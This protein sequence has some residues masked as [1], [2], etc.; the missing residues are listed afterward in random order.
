MKE[1][2]RKEVAQLIVHMERR[3]FYYKYGSWD[4]IIDACKKPS[5]KILVN[6]VKFEDIK[7]LREY[8]LNTVHLEFV[9]TIKNKI[10]YFEALKI[11]CNTGPKAA[12][13]LAR[14]PI[15]AITLY[16][17]M[18]VDKKYNHIEKQ[19]ISKLY[20]KV[21]DNNGNLNLSDYLHAYNSTVEKE[22]VEYMLSKSKTL[23]MNAA[24][25]KKLIHKLRKYFVTK[26]NTYKKECTM[27]EVYTDIVDSFDKSEDVLNHFISMLD[28]E[29]FD[30]HL[31]IIPNI[32]RAVE[33]NYFDEVK[34]T[35]RDFSITVDDI[36][37][38]RKVGYDFCTEDILNKKEDY[39][40]CN[41][42]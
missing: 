12:I 33:I 31:S 23:F 11:F 10:G 26:Q 17:A 41:F 29:E 7:I 2:T 30:K 25:N 13:I 20:P 3:E 9:D 36:F 19:M 35:G 34:N 18:G 4:K 22:Q 1:I 5:P 14:H 28:R 8:F 39:M 6:G 32:M 21:K 15:A 38:S 37:K 42:M 27:K 24:K 40:Q 16:D